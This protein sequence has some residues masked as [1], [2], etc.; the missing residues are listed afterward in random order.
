MNIALSILERLGVFAMWLFRVPDVKPVATEEMLIQP[1]E[2]RSYINFDG[3]DP[4]LLQR[5][6]SESD[7]TEDE[8]LLS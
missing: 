1:S 8:N 3:Y 7:L 5:N 6:R 4:A 2:G